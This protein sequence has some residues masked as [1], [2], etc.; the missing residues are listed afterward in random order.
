MPEMVAE[1]S[2]AGQFSSL[3]IILES[4]VLPVPGGPQ[5]I[6]ELNFFV[7]KNEGII[8]PFPTRCF[9]PSNPSKVEGLNLSARGEKNLPEI[10]YS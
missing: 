6:T 2:M 8:L 1:N 3:I 9:C 5:K 4:V 7:S 10:S